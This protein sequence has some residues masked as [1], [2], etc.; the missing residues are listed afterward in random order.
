MDLRELTGTLIISSL[1]MG[2]LI[3]LMG[4]LIS[5]IEMLISLMGVVGSVTI[6]VIGADGDVD[7]N[8]II[9]SPTDVVIHGNTTEST[10]VLLATLDCLGCDCSGEIDMGAIGTGTPISDESVLKA[11]AMI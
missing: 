8:A 3:S 2:A 5:L 10:D 1:S 6:V 9:P 7:S 11:D 4:M